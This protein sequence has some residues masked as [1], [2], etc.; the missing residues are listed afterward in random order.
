VGDFFFQQGIAMSICTISEAKIVYVPIPKIVID[1]DGIEKEKTKF[2]RSGVR[3]TM[4]DK[5]SWFHSFTHGTWSQHFPQVQKIQHWGAPAFE[6]G[7]TTPIM[8]RETVNKYKNFR[9]VVAEFG[10]RNQG[11]VCALLDGVKQ[12]LQ[13]EEDRRSG[14]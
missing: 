13:D 2:V 5:T 8:I 4:G 7:T 14:G 9:A 12:A 11:L 1:K 10:V 3:I 6:L